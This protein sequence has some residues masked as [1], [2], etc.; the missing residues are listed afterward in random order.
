[1]I[2]V[3]VKNNNG[4]IGKYANAKLYYKKGINR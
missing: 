3:L 4:G 2:T 1:M